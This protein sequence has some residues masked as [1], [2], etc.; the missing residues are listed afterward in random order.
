MQMVQ[1]TTEMDDEDGTKPV[2]VNPMNVTDVTI[3]DS[4]EH[5]LITLTGDRTLFVKEPV[6]TVVRL[7]NRGLSTLDTSNANS[8]T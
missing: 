2:W 7:I 5:T 4:T 6:E 3:S 1:L 8:G